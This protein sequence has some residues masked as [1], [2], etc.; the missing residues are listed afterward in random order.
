MY[1]H[2][3]GISTQTFRQKCQ[4]NNIG[5]TSEEGLSFVVGLNILIIRVYKYI[6]P[7]PAGFFGFPL[8]HSFPW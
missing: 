8:H 6:V 4:S 3:I 5:S 2:L 7:D 1:D